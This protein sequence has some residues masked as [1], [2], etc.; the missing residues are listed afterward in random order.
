M[1]KQIIGHLSFWIILICL[2][3]SGYI[4]IWQ[5][6][7]GVSAIVNYSWLLLVFYTT[8]LTSISFFNNA[9]DFGKI[10][11]YRQFWIIVL[12]PFLYIPGVM[13]TDKYLLHYF[14]PVSLWTYCVSRF[15]MI[16]PFISNAV[17]LAGFQ[18]RAIQFRN[19]RKEL[20]G[21]RGEREQLLKEV[22]LLKFEKIALREEVD[23]IRREYRRNL[24]YYEDI[25][26]RLKNGD[27]D[28]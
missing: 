18:T 11:R 25:I 7:F 13:L 23:E 19:T 26:Q 9:N 4:P 2:D 12:L 24:E 22:N 6:S 3:V 15:I 14:N 27:E 20:G 28:F 5:H 21:L 17:F 1:R 16:Y 10:F 8:Y